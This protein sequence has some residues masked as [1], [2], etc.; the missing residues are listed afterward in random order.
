MRK[1]LIIVTIILLA[2][3]LTAIEIEWTHV[4]DENRHEYSFIQTH[5]DGF[6]IF[7]HINHV[8]A[9]DSIIFTRYNS[10]FEIL[11]MRIWDLFP[12]RSG[13]ERLLALPNG[14]YAMVGNFRPRD[15]YGDET[16]SDIFIFEF[17]DDGDSLFYTILESEIYTTMR[18]AVPLEDG[19]YMFVAYEARGEDEEFIVIRTNSEGEIIMQ[20]RLHR[21]FP[22]LWFGVI[23]AIDDSAFLVGGKL[24][25]AEPYH[26]SFGLIMKFDI[27]GNI[28]WQQTYQAPRD[29]GTIRG[30]LRLPGDR[31]AAHG[32]YETNNYNWYIVFNADGEELVNKRITQHEVGSVS[33][34]TL[35]S[36]GDILILASLASRREYLLLQINQEGDSLDSHIFHEDSLHRFSRTRIISTSDGGAAILGTKNISPNERQLILRDVIIKIAPMENGVVDGNNIEF[37]RTTLLSPAYPNPFNSS[38]TIRY[39]LRLPAPTRV[40]VFDMN[41]QRVTVLDG[42]E[43]GAGVYNLVWNAEGMPA[44][45]YLIR[46][47]TPVM[48]RVRKVVLVP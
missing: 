22:G 35:L 34:G 8:D 47:E 5:D 19:G 9:E 14:S 18:D 39:G 33:W 4:F 10:D 25:I 38:T 27:N 3:S 26:F 32:N 11:W 31:F 12:H 23:I 44:G 17:N 24:Y 13:L 16:G 15:E 48:N 41:G 1:N 28:I 20:E 2:S 43:R 36:N 37:P 46:L 30:I 21:P 40:S 42:G 7:T 6:L 45:V 29:R